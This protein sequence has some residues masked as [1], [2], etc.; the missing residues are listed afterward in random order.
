LLEEGVSVYYLI[1]GERGSGKTS[2]LLYLYDIVQNSNN[3]KIVGKYERSIAGMG[4]I[5]S[6]A[7]KLLPHKTVYY[8]EGHD[9]VSDLRNF[10]V[11]KKYYWFLDVPDSVKPKDIAKLTDGLEILLGFKNVNIFVAMNRSHYNK[12]FDY[13]E[14]LGKFTVIM[15][16]PFTVEETETLIKERIKTFAT[17][18]ENPPQIFSKESIETIWKLSRGNPRNILAACDVCLQRFLYY[19]L[20]GL[21]EIIDSKFV[22]DVLGED[23]P[24]KILNE[25]VSDTTLR[26]HLRQLYQLIKIEFGGRVEKQKFLLEKVKEVYGWS[27]TTTIKRIRMLEKL[28]LITIRKS[29][30]DLW[31]NIIEVVV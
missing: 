21:V 28:G 6:L 7:M 10:L 15:L 11:N 25:R 14:I 1:L 3:P 22:S 26:T 5:Q 29:P 24:N 16:K 18:K 9:Y 27:S 17:D 23:L 12:S 4:S 31:S 20:Q 30:T 19:K 2:T 13:S 8:R